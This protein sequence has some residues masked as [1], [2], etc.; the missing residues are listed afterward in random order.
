MLKAPLVTPTE[1]P[2]ITLAFLN[3]LDRRFPLASPKRG[4]TPEDIWRRAGA[5]EVI[6]Y[7]TRVAEAQSNSKVTT[8]RVLEP[9]PQPDNRGTPARSG[10]A[11]ASPGSTI[12]DRQ[13]TG[14]TGKVKGPNLGQD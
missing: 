3:D 7:L 8:S 9:I 1:C 2:P 5:R 6:D 4:E 14:G 11:P 10:P 13:S 12:R